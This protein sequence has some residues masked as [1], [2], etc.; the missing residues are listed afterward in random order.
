MIRFANLECIK[1]KTPFKL[2]LFGNDSEIKFEHQK[3]NSQENKFT[4]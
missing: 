4:Q 2:I 1:I 3:N